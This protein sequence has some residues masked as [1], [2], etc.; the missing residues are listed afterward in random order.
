MHRRQT[1]K[2][3]MSELCLAV[4][5]AVATWTAVGCS[6]VRPP[7]PTLARTTGFASTSD[8]TPIYYERV[9]TGPAVVLIHGLG[10]NHA[11]WYRQVPSLAREFSVVTISQRGFAPS[12]GSRDRYDVE[13]LVSDLTSVLD[14]LAIEHAAIVGQSMGGWTALGLALEAPQRVTALVLADSLAGIGD[15]RI[16]A[17]Y[18]AMLTKARELGTTPAPLGSHPALASSFSRDHLDQAYLYQLLSTFGA[19]SPSVIASQLA[20]ARFDPGRLTANRVPVLFVVGRGDAIFPVDVVRHAAGMIAS[21]E[22]VVIEDAGHS[23]YFET[24]RAWRDAVVPFLRLAT[25][26]DR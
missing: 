25:A 3:R 23:A 14:A 11:V 24:P 21:S 2:R 6:A 12:G 8:G 1:S 22:V 26:R 7:P 18:R 13:V 4:L 20:A 19:P 15:D 17:H 10:G 9:G 5:L 16:D